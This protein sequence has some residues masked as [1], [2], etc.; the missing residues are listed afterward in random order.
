MVHS[1]PEKWTR[2][3]VLSFVS[4]PF[5]LI[6]VVWRWTSKHLP[7]GSTP[8]SSL[9]VW[10]QPLVFLLFVLGGSF[11]ALASFCFLYFSWWG[12]P[13]VEVV[14]QPPLCLMG[15]AH[16]WYGSWS[17]APV[18]A[19]SQTFLLC[20]WCWSGF[21]QLQHQSELLQSWGMVA[22]GWGAIPLL[23]P[24]LAPQNQLGRSILGF[25]QDIFSDSS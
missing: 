11:S 15:S 20:H 17:I 14:S 10:E 24:C 3:T 23:F 18:E 12:C 21:L 7:F 5:C 9:V 8:I 22:Q 13:P 6:C 2:M 1:W 16:T 19:K 25:S 4:T